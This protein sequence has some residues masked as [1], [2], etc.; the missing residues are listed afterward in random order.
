M[1]SKYTTNFETSNFSSYI[2]DLVK[3]HKK[4]I[5]FAHHKVMLDAISEKLQKLN[6]KFIRIDGST[7]S[8]LRSE[9]ID[10][11]QNKKSC[12]VAVLSLKGM[13]Q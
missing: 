13:L 6:V 8:D 7:R 9:Y 2:R 5:V 3:E 1:K 12:Q 4:F 11:F 10:R